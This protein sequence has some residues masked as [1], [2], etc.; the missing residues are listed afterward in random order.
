[1]ALLHGWTAT[2]FRAQ[3]YLRPRA[4]CHREPRREKKARWAEHPRDSA[5]PEE[6]GSQDRHRLRDAGPP[7]HGRCGGVCSC[8]SRTGWVSRASRRCHRSRA[9][10]VAIDVQVSNIRRPVGRSSARRRRPHVLARA[11]RAV[12]DGVLDQRGH[13]QADRVACDQ[14]AHGHGA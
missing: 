7:S 1:M 12:D 8:C 10:L 4:A 9:A 3:T 2:F 11:A 13:G 6:L 14:R 5:G